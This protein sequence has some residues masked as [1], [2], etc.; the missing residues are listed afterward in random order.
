MVTPVW[1]PVCTAANAAVSVPSVTR[2]HRKPI[3]PPT[4][5]AAA[6]WVAM[7]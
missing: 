7:S 5:V 4:S 3:A 1:P 6:M 2:T